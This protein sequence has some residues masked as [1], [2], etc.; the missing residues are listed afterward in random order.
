MPFSDPTLNNATRALP[1]R[2]TDHYETD[3]SASFQELR[4]RQVPSHALSGEYAA[5]VVERYFLEDLKLIPQMEQTDVTEF[6]AFLEGRTAY[7][8]FDRAMW[9]IGMH[10]DLA[11]NSVKSSEGA[12]GIVQIWD[13]T[14]LELRSEYGP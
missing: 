7:N 14:C 12:I 8:P 4:E 10:G 13:K 5:D 9:R 3:L 11:Y 6:Y 2:G 1:Q